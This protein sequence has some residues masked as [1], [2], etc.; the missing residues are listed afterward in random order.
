MNKELLM[1]E[2]SNNLKEQHKIIMNYLNDNIP[3]ILKYL[4]YTQIF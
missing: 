4:K 2:I 1:K 3:K